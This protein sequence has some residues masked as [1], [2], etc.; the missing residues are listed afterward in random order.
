MGETMNILL[1]LFISLGSI[2]VLSPVVAQTEAS[3]W[4]DGPGK[5]LIQGQCTVCHQLNRITQSSGYT[6]AGW[7][8]LIATMVNLDGNPNREMI[9]AYLA[10]HFPQSSKHSPHLLSGSTTITF[11]EW[12]VPTLGQRARDPMQTPD[13]AIWWAGQWGNLIGKIDPTNNEMTEYPLPVGSMP[14]SVTHDQ[15]GNI[16]YTGNKNGTVGKLTP[17]TGELTTF[18]MPDPDAKDPHTAIFDSQGA[19]WFTL[20]HSNMVGR[21]I[22]QTGDIKL[23][24]LPTKNSRP[25]GITLDTNGNPWVACNGSNCLIKVNS[26]TMQLHEYKLPDPAT[27]VRRLDFASDGMLWYV[28][29]SQGRLGRFDPVSG[30]AKEWPSPSGPESHPYAIAVVDNV[31]WYNESGMRPDTLVR[32][33]PN[34]ETFQS[35]PIPSGEVYAGIVR[36]MRATRE[37][38]LLIHQSSTNRIILVTPN[39]A[40]NHDISI[41]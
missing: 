36:H 15:A 39:R 34:T 19:M 10:T 13:S 16:W 12:T 20:Q 23:V 29:S 41:P 4:P 11:K 35:W 32:F 40:S 33:E 26:K 21:L 8:E 14:H 2:N 17:S 25:Y 18:K 28:N 30:I 37:G 6:Q 38:N 31:I 3:H 24:T 7:Q 1:K 22:P 9:A 27:T 5:K